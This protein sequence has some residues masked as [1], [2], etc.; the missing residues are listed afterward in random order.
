MSAKSRCFATEKKVLPLFGHLAL[1]L[2]RAFSFIHDSIP[3]AVYAC[4]RG[5]PPPLPFSYYQLIGPSPSPVPLQSSRSSRPSPP[6]GWM[7]GLRGG[8]GWRASERMGGRRE[9]RRG[10]GDGGEGGR[11]WIGHPR[12]PAH[13]TPIVC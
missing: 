3:V 5:T 6:D 11:G 9:G 12:S 10:A 1:F 4:N 13:R 8:A 7:D 2:Y